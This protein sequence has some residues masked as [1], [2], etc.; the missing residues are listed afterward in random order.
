[1]WILDNQKKKNRMIKERPETVMLQV[2]YSYII[3]NG[4]FEIP[5]AKKPGISKP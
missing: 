2:F 3:M 1:M 5:K 4:M